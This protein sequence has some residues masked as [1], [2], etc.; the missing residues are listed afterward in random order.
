SPS[1]CKGQPE[2]IRS[3]TLAA[4]AETDPRFAEARMPLTRHMVSTLHRWALVKKWPVNSVHGRLRY[5]VWYASEFIPS[6]P[7]AVSLNNDKLLLELNSEVIAYLPVS[8]FWME[9]WRQHYSRRTDC[10]I[11]EESGYFN[12][13]TEALHFLYHRNL[14]HALFPAYMLE[15]LGELQPGFGSPP[16]TRCF[17]CIW[18]SSEFYKKKYHDIR[19]PAV[20][21]SFTFDLLNH[22]VIERQRD[23]FVFPEC[24]RYWSADFSPGTPYLTRFSIA[25]AALSPRFQKLFREGRTTPAKLAE[26]DRWVKH[27]LY[28]Q[29]PVLRRFVPKIASE[30][31]RPVFD[32]D[33]KF[34]FGGF[35]RPTEERLFS[36]VGFERTR[37]GDAIDV[38]VVGPAGAASG[39]GAGMRRSI[40]ALEQAG[41]CFRV[42]E[43]YYDIPSAPQ[44]GVDE[45]LVYRGE[46]PKVTLWHFN[47]E[48][49]PEVMSTMDEIVHLAYN[50]AYFFWETEAMPVAHELACRMVDE[51]WAPS[52]FCA[53]A[54]SGRAAPVV[55]VGSSVQ[56]P[57]VKPYLTRAE[58]GLPEETFV[59]LFSFDSHSVIHRKNPA[60]VVRAFMK[61]F[62]GGDEN[63]MLIIKT[64]NMATA[65]WNNINGRGEE[66]LELCASD[67]RIHF[68]DRTMSLRELYSLKNACDCYMSLHRSEGYGY[69]PAEA[70]AIGKP[71]IMTGYSANVEFATGDNC[72]LIDG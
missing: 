42:L 64:Q 36:E 9:V 26:V 72:V 16:I 60:A 38:L 66:L 3:D 40:G 25:L 46:T 21:D 47:G 50:I 62:P 67:S 29:L 7:V 57:D 59:V 20:R 34:I 28:P 15:N 41:V 48:Y 71:V 4:M 65:H 19:N 17:Y 27:E 44:L 23:L 14:P 5:I 70:M 69:G 1:G 56:L 30:S 2:V 58:L 68:F 33:R 49:L 22:L 45:K 8:V 61:A 37:A 53:S 43:S 32:R 6:R 52:E 54:Y 10:N 39:L 63:A 55:N 51:I 12:F 35:T 11:F 31:G 24:E 13:L 18:G